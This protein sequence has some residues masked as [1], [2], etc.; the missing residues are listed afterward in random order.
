MTTDQTVLNALLERV[1][2]I[3]VEVHEDGPIPNTHKYQPIQNIV[4]N[5][6]SFRAMDF[7]H[8]IGTKMVNLP[9]GDSDEALNFASAYIKI[10]DLEAPNLTYKSGLNYGSDVQT[11]YSH[12]VGVGMS[13]LIASSCFG[14][15]IDQ[16]EPI[17]G[18]GTRFDY[19]GISSGLTYLIESRGTKYGYEQNSQVE[20][21]LRKKGVIINRGDKF[22]VG[23]IVSTFIGEDPMIP[24]ILV[25][26][27]EYNEY[28]FKGDSKALFRYR[29]FTRVMQFIGAT[30][31]ARAL[32]LESNN[33][34]NGRPSKRFFF[35]DRNVDTMGYMT[36]IEVDKSFYVG[37]W[38]D[39]WI[40][41][42]SLRY[43][44]LAKIKLPTPLESQPKL[45]LSV[46]RGLLDIN[47][48]AIINGE[49]EE[50]DIPTG[51]KLTTIKETSE[52]NI[53]SVLPDGT[54]LVFK[55]YS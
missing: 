11:M 34:R 22:D 6:F 48:K 40:P 28:I 30:P 51:D 50:I 8:C 7:F 41:K 9:L 49:V 17:P 20:G 26:D 55:A 16:F 10:L 2:N 24:N 54:I 45:K 1:H 4:Q 53:S 3:S 52:G 35:K 15:P 12:G 25:A 39:N 31:L 27:P 18:R 44:R 19:R 37:H 33:I 42:E 13:C 46:F 32:Y 43:S 23:L 21:G 5:G 14:I 47:L 29:H 38:S 36:G